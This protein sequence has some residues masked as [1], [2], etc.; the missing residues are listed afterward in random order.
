MKVLVTGG[1]GYIGTHTALQLMEAG[2]EPVLLDNFSNASS[3]AIGALARLAGRDLHWVEGDVRDRSCLDRLFGQHDFR[4]VVHL[5]ALKAVGESVAEPLSYYSTNLV[6]TACLL[7]RMAH[8]DVRSL[9]FSSTATVYAP[10]SEP[11]TETAKKG[12]ASPYA[13]SKLAAEEMLRDLSAADANWRVSVLRYFN[14]GG[15]H[16][17]GLI[18]ESPTGSSQNLLPIVAEV[19]TGQRDRLAVFGDDYPTP[20]GTCIRDYV[21]VVDIAQA[22]VHALERV[23]REPGFSVHNLGTGRGHSVLEVTHAFE[24]I[25]GVEVPRQVAARRP[26]DVAVLCADSSLARRELKWGPT[27]DLNL[28]CADLW[29][30]Q[31]THPEG[32]AD[33]KNARN[34]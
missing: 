4:A 7:E 24:R 13:R 30:W 18:G 6:G 25:S 32:Y 14:A 21:H 10:S 11:L 2:W 1:A 3:G 31:S 8:H 26:G 12:P 34:G 9:V 22:H 15:A 17:S 5:A 28:I 19:A 27:R 20:D 23:L 29:R 33:R 16:P